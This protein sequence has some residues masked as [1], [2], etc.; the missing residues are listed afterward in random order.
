MSKRSFFERL[1]G[2]TNVEGTEFPATDF[3]SQDQD[4][5]YQDNEVNIHKIQH[6]EDQDL[7]E[8]DESQE[9]DLEGE[10]AVDVYDLGSVMVIK[11]MTAGVKKEDLEIHI[12]RDQ[13]AIRGSRHDAD[14][15]GE[16]HFI[17]QE[18]Y[19]GAFSRVVSLPAEIDIDHA[20]AQEAYGVLT[21]TL[22]K[23]DTTRMSQL[24]VK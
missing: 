15:P 9:E 1:T 19:W 12:T 16:D 17:H 14:A 7:S 24:R 11:A 8:N 4:M 20:K 22:P 21:I 23:S 5:Y 3:G 13:V 18:L 6:S 10:L 2:A